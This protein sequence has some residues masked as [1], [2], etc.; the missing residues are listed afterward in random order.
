MSEP[1]AKHLLLIN[2]G[3]RFDEAQ[4]RWFFPRNDASLAQWRVKSEEPD[5][6]HKM[7]ILLERGFQ[8]TGKSWRRD[9]WVIAHSRVLLLKP[10]DLLK[11]VR[12]IQ[13]SVTEDRQ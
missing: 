7:M 8:S 11:A 13:R 1:D 10:D 6:V 3:W 9:D 5:H 4:Q 12:L 2:R